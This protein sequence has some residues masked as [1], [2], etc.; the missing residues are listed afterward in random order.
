MLI[1]ASPAPMI[2]RTSRT[3][4][5][6]VGLGWKEP[7]IVLTVTR[8]TFLGP[9]ANWPSRS[10]VVFPAPWLTGQARRPGTFQ[11][12]QSNAFCRTILKAPRNNRSHV[13]AL[14]RKWHPQIKKN[15][16]GTPEISPKEN[17][18]TSRASSLFLINYW[19]KFSK[20]SHLHQAHNGNLSI[21]TSNHQF[22]TSTQERNK[23]N[24]EHWIYWLRLKHVSELRVSGASTLSGPSAC[25]NTDTT[26]CAT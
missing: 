15:S 25:N 6:I 1:W 11:N 19:N 12:Q 9:P 5:T 23:K 14:I 22:R 24:L 17:H 3:R 21:L 7:E 10:V 18:T 13:L 8:Q 4:G 26:R 2:E 16:N 20:F